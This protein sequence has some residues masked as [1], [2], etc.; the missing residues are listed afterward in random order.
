MPGPLFRVL[1]QEVK[2]RGWDNRDI[3]QIISC[4]SQHVSDILNGRAI[5]TQ[6]QQYA[7]MDSLK[8]PY[9]DMYLIFPKDGIEIKA[10]KRVEIVR[11]YCNETGKILVD[12]STAE[13]LKTAVRAL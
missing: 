13:I 3:A 8:W 9:V 7:L 10:N 12:K 1:R 4:S 6:A 5:F 2:D 11:E